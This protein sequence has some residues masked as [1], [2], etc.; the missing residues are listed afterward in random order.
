MTRVSAIGVALIGLGIATYLT[1]VHYAGASPVCAIAH[2]CETVQKSHY[3]ML[4]GVPVA[5]LGGLTYVGILATLARDNENA[6]TAGAMLAIVGVG[7][8]AWLTFVEVF[9]LHAICIW[10]VGSAICM[11]LL[12]ILTVTRLLAADS[13]A[14][15]DRQGREPG[16]SHR[17]GLPGSRGGARA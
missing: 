10:C 16:L 13:V 15:D 4:F 12:A 5:L 6:R 9:K 17:A 3:S 11:A 7:F 1:V 8:S 14:S 2:G